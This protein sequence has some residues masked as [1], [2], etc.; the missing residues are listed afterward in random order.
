MET[1]NDNIE[2]IRE[3]VNRLLS[4]RASHLEEIAELK[5]ELEF[6]RKQP[7]LRGAVLENDLGIGK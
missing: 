4:D 1:L 3:L 6:Y 2:E 7:H 5:K